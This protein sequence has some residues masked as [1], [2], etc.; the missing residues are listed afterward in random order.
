MNESEKY[1]IHISWELY[2]NDDVCNDVP[3]R[4]VRNAVRIS[5]NTV[6]YVELCY[7]YVYSVIKM[8]ISSDCE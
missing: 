6:T 7:V 3:T 8:L 4:S 1:E 5:I 2:K